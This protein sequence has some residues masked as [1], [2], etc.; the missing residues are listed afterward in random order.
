MDYRVFHP[1]L[2]S[3]GGPLLFALF[4]VLLFLEYRWSLRRWVNGFVRRLITNAAVALPTLFVM[5]LGL[6]PA[7]VAAAHWARQQEFGLLH[8][9][10]LPTW[11]HAVLAFL[12]L[13]YSLYV[14]HVLSHKVP[15]LWRFHNVHHTDLDLG[16]STAIRFHFGEMLLSGMFRT[17]WVL[18]IGAGPLVVLV[19]EIV[20]EASVAFHHSNWRLPYRLERVLSWVVVTPRM[21]GIHHSVVRRETDSNYSNL[22]NVWD[23][24]HRT[25]RLNVRQDE[26]TVGVPGYREGHDLTV[27]GLLTLP[28]RRQRDYWLLPDG[29]RPDRLDKGNRDQLSP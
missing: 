13:D 5:R 22:L 9:L 3:Y 19:Y 4:V 11:L 27:L 8:L 7:V 2:D 6:I 14:W 20:F 18:L 26:I 23:R 17:A 1:E 24:L 28:F 29:T 15:L 25:I 10:P 21:H 16:V 12:L